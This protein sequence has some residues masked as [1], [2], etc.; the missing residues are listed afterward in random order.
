MFIF[1]CSLSE[2]YF[3]VKS[4]ALVLG[5]N[6][7]LLRSPFDGHRLSISSTGSAG[8]TSTVSASTIGGASGAATAGSD[9]QQHL[10]SMFYLLRPEET[11]K[12]VSHFISLYYYL[13][14]NIKTVYIIIYVCK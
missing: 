10:Q 4:S 11:L 8:S 14:C 6:E 5:Q 12:M 3:A 13:I 1:I 2:C 9:I 7:R